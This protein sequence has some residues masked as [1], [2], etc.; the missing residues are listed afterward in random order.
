[1]IASQALGFGF[2]GPIREPFSEILQK[3]ASSKAQIVSIDVPSGWPV[4]VE[5]PNL[6][7]LIRP[8]VLISLTAPKMCARHLDCRHYLGGRFLTP[9]LIQSYAIDIP[10]YSDASQF[11]RLN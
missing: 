3:L 10:E 6:E 2:E 11:I 7:S 1:M 5:S 8:S 4:D 9:H